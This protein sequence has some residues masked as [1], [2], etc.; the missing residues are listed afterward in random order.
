MKD[1]PGTKDVLDETAVASV[2]VL[3][4][5]RPGSPPMEQLVPAYVFE[6]S[7]EDAAAKF[8]VA[9]SAGSRVPASLAV[10]NG[11]PVALMISRSSFVGVPSQESDV[12]LGRFTGP[13][14]AALA[15]ARSA[16]SRTRA[17]SITSRPPSATPSEASGG[18]R[19]WK[20]PTAISRSS[21]GSAPS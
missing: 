17:P 9:R 18:S 2:L 3:V 12:S 6:L 20:C 11:C 15:A 14:L 21:P 1:A 13:V 16:N 7:S 8:E 19:S 10:G 5:G 4:L